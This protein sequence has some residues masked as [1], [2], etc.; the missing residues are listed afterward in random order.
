MTDRSDIDVNAVRKLLEARRAEIVERETSTKESRDPVELDQQRVGRLSRM[1][2]LQSQAMA[3]DAERR[4]KIEVQKIDAA[5]ERIESGDYGYCIT[6]G[7]EI[8]KARLE[9]D[10]AVAICVDCA[11]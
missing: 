2:A 5:L 1:D 3:Q 8:P 9:F 4:R 7:E 11:Q 10:P 6:C